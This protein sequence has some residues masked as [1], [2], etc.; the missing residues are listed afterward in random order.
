MLILPQ[1]S[2]Y[3]IAKIDNGMKGVASKRYAAHLMEI[4]RDKYE[5]F[6]IESS[7]RKTFRFWQ[8]GGGFDRNLWNAKAI[9]DSIRYIEA[10]PVR[11]GLVSTPGEYRWSSA[12]SRAKGE[13]VVPD[14]C[15]LPVYM[16]D[17]QYQR[18][19]I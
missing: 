5:E 10:N 1:E 3:D 12:Y 19:G 8:P 4:D 7:G 15:N 18:L 2:H 16:P 17:P 14:K 6:V 11:R 13:G 9:H